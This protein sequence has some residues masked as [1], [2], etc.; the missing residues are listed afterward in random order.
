MVPTGSPKRAV[1]PRRRMSFSLLAL[2]LLSLAPARSIADCGG[3]LHTAYLSNVPSYVAILDAAG[4]GAGVLY[5]GTFRVCGAP[6]AIDPY[7][8]H[9]HPTT[10]G[11]MSFSI[12]EN[13]DLTFQISLGGT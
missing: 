3:E 10:N 7:V 9:G 4:A 5:S 8:Q 12:D 13:F 1:D 2:A 11:T 6:S